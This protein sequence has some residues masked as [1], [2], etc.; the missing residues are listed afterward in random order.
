MCGLVKAVLEEKLL[1][2]LLLMVEL[3]I[4]Q[5]AHEPEPTAPLVREL[6]RLIPTNWVTVALPVIVLT[7][8]LLT[9]EV[10]LTV[11]LEQPLL[12]ALPPLTALPIFIPT[13]NA[14]PP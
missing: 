8:L 12:P 3:M 1:E 10:L 2:V 9:I 14:F 11:Q 6:A 13:A 4:E 5:F 7:Q